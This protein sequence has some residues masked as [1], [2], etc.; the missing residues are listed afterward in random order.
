MNRVAVNSLRHRRYAAE[1]GVKI[2]DIRGIYRLM[3]LRI[4]PRA[5]HDVRLYD[6]QSKN[7]ALVV[8]ETLNQTPCVNEDIIKRRQEAHE[9][10]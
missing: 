2:L 6:I 1:G 9:G 3:S 4:W 5:N 8:V 7:L 10:T